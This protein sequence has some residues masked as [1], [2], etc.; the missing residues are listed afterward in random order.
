MTRHSSGENAAAK[1]LTVR[2]RSQ[3]TDAPNIPAETCMA[4]L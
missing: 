1:K 2:Y 4:A 3:A